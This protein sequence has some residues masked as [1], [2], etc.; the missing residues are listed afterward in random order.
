M[1]MR[2]E[3]NRISRVVSV[4]RSN[5]ARGQGAGGRRYPWLTLALRGAARRRH[6]SG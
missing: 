1:S 4:G 5:I 2:R 6:Q 3:P